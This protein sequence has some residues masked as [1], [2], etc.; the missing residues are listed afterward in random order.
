LSQIKGTLA[1]TSGPDGEELFTPVAVMVKSKVASLNFT[2][3]SESLPDFTVGALTRVIIL[4]LP[5]AIEEGSI[6]VPDTALKVVAG[7]DAGCFTL[8]GPT[9]TVV[10][11]MADSHASANLDIPASALG[12]KVKASSL[13]SKTALANVNLNPEAARADGLAAI[14]AILS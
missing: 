4:A 13:D 9:K 7:P 6:T 5:A 10:A 12:V 3:N 8:P 14:D 1:A 11:L 2:A